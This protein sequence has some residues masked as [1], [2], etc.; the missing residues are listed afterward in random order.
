MQDKL[1]ELLTRRNE[2]TWQ[3]IIQDLMK[4]EELD[5]WNVEISVLANRYRKALVVMKEHNFF[6]SGKI[7]FALAFL[8]KLKSDRFLSE[9][10]ANFDNQLFPPRDE[11]IF[12]DDSSTEDN[13]YA[14]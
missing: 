5:P 12:S 13:P 9:H 3:T 1:Y 7:V 6:I 2:I 11:D 14:H 10:I 4:T 8:L